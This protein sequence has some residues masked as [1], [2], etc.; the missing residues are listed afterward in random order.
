MFPL[1][2]VLS[3]IHNPLL[4]TQGNRKLNQVLGWNDPDVLM[5]RYIQDVRE[6]SLAYAQ[7]E[8]V[9]RIDV[10]GFPIKADGFRYTEESFLRCW[11]ARSGFHQPDLVDYHALLDEFGVIR[12]INSD[13]ID[14][15][16]LFGFPYAGYYESI[17]AGPG[18]FW[19][20]AP[21]LGGASRAGT[22][23]APT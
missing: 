11:R 8:I 13:A 4:R 21:P 9:E 20:N 1:R 22:S 17:M 10:D 14:E 12:K 23:P 2:R 18:A 15:V 7:F 16:W 19:C 3:I 5:Q 6:A